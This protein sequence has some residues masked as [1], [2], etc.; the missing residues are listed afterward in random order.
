KE[1]GFPRNYTIT[2]VH[3]KNRGYVRTVPRTRRRPLPNKKGLHHSAIRSLSGIFPTTA[4]VVLRNL[5]SA[6]D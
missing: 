4:L 6:A 3:A 5:S 1:E 2:W